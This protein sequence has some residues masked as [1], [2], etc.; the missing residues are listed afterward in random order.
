MFNGVVTGKIGFVAKSF[1]EK[2]WIIWIET[3]DW[4]VGVGEVKEWFGLLVSLD[5]YDRRK[6]IIG[7]GKY[8]G[9]TLYKVVAQLDNPEGGNNQ[10]AVIL[11]YASRL[12][13]L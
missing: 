3:R 2:A 5:E 8:I 1:D 13:I 4:K 9:A 7:Q 6:A 11:G 10:S 12:W